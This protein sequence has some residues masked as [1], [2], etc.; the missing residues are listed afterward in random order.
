MTDE[1]GKVALDSLADQGIHRT[2][3]IC[4]S[5]AGEGGSIWRRR[6]IAMGPQ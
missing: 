3:G 2:Q 4:L 6:P 1:L 5:S